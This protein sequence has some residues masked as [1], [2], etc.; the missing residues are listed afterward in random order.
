MRALT[1]SESAG[2]ASLDPSF[3][4]EW[5]FNLLTDR[6]QDESSNISRTASKGTSQYKANNDDDAKCQDGISVHHVPT[7]ERIQD[8]PQA[9][10][11]QASNVVSISD[12]PISHPAASQLSVH[13][14]SNL[15]DPQYPYRQDMSP[16]HAPQDR[17]AV[18]EV[19]LKAIAQGTRPEHAECF[20]TLVDE[21][22]ITKLKMWNIVGSLSETWMGSIQPRLCDLLQHNWH[23]LMR[24]Q[25]TTGAP[26]YTLRAYLIGWSKRHAAPHV[27]LLSCQNYESF[28]KKARRIV[29]KHGLLSSHGWGPSFVC[30]RLQTGV[31][32]PMLPYYSLD[33]RPYYPSAKAQPY[34]AS[35]EVHSDADDI[36][37]SELCEHL[38]PR[39]LC[40][41]CSRGGTQTVAGLPSSL[42]PE[43]T[44][45]LYM[46]GNSNGICGT[47]FRTSSGCIGTLGGTLAIDDEYY[48]LT[49]GHTFGQT[50]SWEKTPTIEEDDMSDISDDLFGYDNEDLALI[51]N[52]SSEYNCQI[53]LDDLLVPSLIGVPETDEQVS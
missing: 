50:E 48:G 11:E 14:Q 25:P 16:Q 23:R 40:E 38:S 6:I 9:R 34:H 43:E 3:P 20:G 32:Q 46:I 44:W 33:P 24:H 41:I 1:Q 4:R 10:E 22:P 29:L 7:E 28:S 15:S 51:R 21:M 42:E 45:S 5:R 31:I 19:H 13:P 49:A 35:P 18:R 47:K 30:L 26:V 53:Q 12:E 39:N 2:N 37:S 17:L 36:G 8:M 52:I 27:A